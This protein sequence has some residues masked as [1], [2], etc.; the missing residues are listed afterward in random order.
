MA[1][2]PQRVQLSRTH[3]WR[4]PPGAV[5]ID[6]STIWGNPWKAG[7]PGVFWM[8]LPRSGWNPPPMCGWLSTMFM[9][10]PVTPEM[11][12]TFYERWL[13]DSE[14]HLPVGLTEAGARAVRLALHDRRLLILH[15]LPELRRRPLACWCSPDAPCHAHALLRLA[16]EA[17]E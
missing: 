15:R 16:N 14:T 1:D 9:A 17:P 5:K 13:R 3:G 7:A 12:V 8:P 11:S 4:M 6:R 10:F 2:L